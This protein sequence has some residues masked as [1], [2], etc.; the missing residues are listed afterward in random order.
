MTASPRGAPAP[1]AGTASPPGDAPWPPEDDARLIER[2]R[3]HPDAF[4][5][6]YDRHAPSIHRY[7]ARRRTR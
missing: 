3:S 5:G 4:A 1:P 6:L 7:A 2:S